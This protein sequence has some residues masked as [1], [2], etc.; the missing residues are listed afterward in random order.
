[1]ALAV[2]ADRD[3]KLVEKCALNLVV[4]GGGPTGTEIAGP[5]ADMIDLTILRRNTP[6]LP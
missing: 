4:A 3:P 2:F 6:I 5:L 1:M